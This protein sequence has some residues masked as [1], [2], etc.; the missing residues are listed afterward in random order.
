MNDTSETVKLIER[1]QD[2]QK[3]NIR[4]IQRLTDQGAAINP[5]ALRDM[6]LEALCDYLIGGAS[7]C[8]RLRF[9]IKLAK[10]I[11]KA[12]VATSNRVKR[13]KTLSRL[14]IPPGSGGLDGGHM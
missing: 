9:E 2:L 13:E 6:R 12:L 8:T 5:D 10:K 7:S 4:A 3:D 14:R 11:N 1:L